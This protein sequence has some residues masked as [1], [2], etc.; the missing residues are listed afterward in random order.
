MKPQS[1][2]FLTVCL[3]TLLVLS[4]ALAVISVVWQQH[5]DFMATQHILYAVNHSQQLTANEEN[6]TVR[7]LLQLMFFTPISLYLGIYLYGRYIVYR[8]AVWKRQVEMLERLWQQ[9]TALEGAT[10]ETNSDL[11]LN[12]DCWHRSYRN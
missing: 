11:N 8:A 12:S 3:L 5:L 9:N 4:P 6:T 7:V 2:N 10:D 1:S